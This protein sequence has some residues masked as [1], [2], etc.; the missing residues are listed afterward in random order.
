M[1]VSTVVVLTIGSTSFVTVGRPDPSNWSLDHYKAGIR[2][3][4]NNKLPDAERE[5]TTA[6][7]YVPDNAEILFALGNLRLGQKN[8]GAAKQWYRKCLELDPNHSGAWNNAGVIAME[9][10]RWDIAERAFLQ[11]L[12]VEPDSARTLYLVARTRRELGNR[13]GAL[14]A[15][16][17]A[18][19]LA[20]KQPE[21][22]ELREQIIAKP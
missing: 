18:I 6:Y 10:K 2:Y 11:S 16:E 19:R 5:L 14:T 4:S 7:A 22:L 9:E 20:P 3:L 15:I 12:R 1:L 17:D 21:L 8:N 13:Q